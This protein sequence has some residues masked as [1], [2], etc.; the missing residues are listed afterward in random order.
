MVTSEV[1][2]SRSSAARA[3][4]SLVVRTEW[5]SF[6]PSSQIG[7]QS[8]SAMAATSL[9]PVCSSSTSMSDWGDSSRRP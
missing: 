4:A 6:N 3:S 9:T 8:R 1:A 5:P 7:Y 2:V